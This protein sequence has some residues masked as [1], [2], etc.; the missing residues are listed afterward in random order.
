MPLHVTES[1]PP[2]APSLVLLH[3]GGVGGWMWEQH[4]AGLQAD[5]HCL[6]PD[7]P[8]HGQSTDAG[9]FSILD[10]A[11]A[12]AEL[13]HTRAHGGQAHLAGLSLGGQVGVALLGLTPQ[14]VDRAVF[15]GVLARRPGA[16]LFGAGLIGPLLRLYAPFKNQPA[17]IRANQRSLAV[18]EA[19]A[20]QF[21]AATRAASTATLGRIFAANL[22]FEIPPGLSRRR[23]PTLLLVGEKE[24]S[25]VKR[26]TRALSG[27]MLGGT[28]LM[29]P[30][31]VH[32][33]PLIQPDRFVTI[34]RAWLTG[35]PLPNDLLPVPRR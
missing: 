30:G 25:L 1:G 24:P 29:L 31:A 15:S 6:V 12:V 16:A 18:P 28:A 4:V 23:Q 5:Y 35:S 10:A 13:I 32:N 7:L 26:S 21:A 2:S 20:A 8:E 27:A 19:Y 3:G 22:A 11:R 9:L 33:W 34:L 17:L 14:L